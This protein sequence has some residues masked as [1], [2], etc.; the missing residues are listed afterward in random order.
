MNRISQHLAVLEAKQKRTPNT[1]VL[2]TKE[3]DAEKLHSW[4]QG[5]QAG[6]N[7]GFKAGLKSG[8]AEAEHQLLVVGLLLGCSVGLLGGYCLRVWL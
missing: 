7:V 3:L 4:D 2:S 6:N 1:H 8:K 5:F